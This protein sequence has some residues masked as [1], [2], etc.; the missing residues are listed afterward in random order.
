MLVAMLAE[1][2]REQGADR[3]AVILSL[4]RICDHLDCFKLKVNQIEGKSE[5]GEVAHASK[6]DF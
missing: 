3:S 6:L 4:Q 2:S 5:Q 1:S